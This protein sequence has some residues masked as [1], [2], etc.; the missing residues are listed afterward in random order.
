MKF[1]E[2]WLINN[3]NKN[4]IFTFQIAIKAVRTKEPFSLP[5]NYPGFLCSTPSSEIW[6]GFYKPMQGGNA[7]NSNALFVFLQV[8]VFAK[9]KPTIG[10]C[11]K[12]I[13][14]LLWINH[15]KLKSVCLVSFFFKDLLLAF[16]LKCVLKRRP[17][18]G[19]SVWVY[20]MF[21]YLMFFVGNC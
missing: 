12:I 13:C 14:L 18:L 20:F 16:L 5:L 1:K 9:Y 21:V 15:L 11:A 19:N 17:S 6:K 2:T 3:L 4:F 8:L 7:V 10:K